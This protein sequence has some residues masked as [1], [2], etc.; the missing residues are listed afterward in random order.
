MDEDQITARDSFWACVAG[1]LVYGV[2]YLGMV[3]ALALLWH[4]P[5]ETELL[6]VAAG[7]VSYLAFL[8]QMSFSQFRTIALLLVAVSI[9]LALTAGLWLLL[10]MLLAGG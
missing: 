8:V 5:P 9:A 3:I 4:A 2:F 10:F 6:A 7:G 1:A